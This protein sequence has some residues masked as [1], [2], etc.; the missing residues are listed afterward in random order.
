M[1]ASGAKFGRYEIQSQLGAGG[2]GEVYL[3]HDTEL[4]RFVALKVLP[5]EFCCDAE[6]VSRFKQEA[7]AAS[8]LNHPNIITIYEIGEVEDR[9]FI[10]TEFIDGET[11]RERIEKNDLTTY[12]SVK[13]AEQVAAALS[14]AH[15]S[16]IIHRDIK[17]EN[18]MIRRDRIVKILD[19][20]L[21]KLV[22]QR[23]DALDTEAETRAQVNTKAGMI[24][25]T[26]AYM[27]PEQA[28]GK[29]VDARTDIWSLGVVLYEMLTR[30][31]P[32]AGE[33]ISDSI[34]SILK[35]EHPPLDENTP[36][37][38][39]RIVRKALQKNADERYQTIKDFLIDLKNLK[40][41][42]EFTE[43]L[44]R[45]HRPSYGSK[46]PSVSTARLSEDA[47]IIKNAAAITDNRNA[48][49]TSS[50]E[51]VVS[52]IKQHKSASLVTLVV[53]LSAI[54]ALGVW[55]FASRSANATQIESIAVLP[56]VNET[57]NTDNEYLSDGMTESLISS[58]SQIPKLN[59]KA[60]SSVFRYKGKET[61]LRKIAEELN[62]QAILNGR[63]AQRGH[64][65]T[66]YIELVDT[67]TEKVLWSENYNRQMMNLVTLQNEI[68]RDVS[69]KLRTRLSGA[70]EQRVTK[71]HTVNPE[72]YQLYLKGR[73]HWNKRTPEEHKKA[74]GYFEQ[75]I[76]LDPNYALAYA[77]L[78]DCYAVS[79]SP[80]KG[81][82]REQKLRAAANKALELDP[83]LGEPHAALAKS[84]SRE[85]NWS[86]AESEYRRAIEL[87]PNYASAH[88]WYGE[89]LAA[90]GRHDESIRE[91]KRAQEIDPLS[92]VINSD[93]THIL[94]L[95]RRYDE[96]IAQAQKTLEMDAGWMRARW[97][98]SMA[99]LYQDR[100]EEFFA[101][102]EKSLDFSKRSPEEI[103]DYKQELAA[104]K[105]AYRKSG[106][107]GFWQK[108]LEFEMQ[109]YAKGKGN[110]PFYVAE[111]YANLGDKDKALEWLSK[112]I[113]ER[114]DNLEWIKVHPAFDDLRS[115][116]RFQ[117]LL[118]RINLAP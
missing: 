50:A 16:N 78:A 57:G 32:F 83:G 42:L 7:R 77:G 87:N 11:L 28:R 94:L 25:G 98:I 93:M 13:I 53:L 24:M 107:K 23:K 96:A 38:L 89:F 73:F 47:T 20:G 48:T 112:A 55:F 2:M 66:L 103:A 14:V 17:P 69:H 61:D 116:P 9:I 110:S 54:G 88:Q 35:S 74:I 113:D 1:I 117:N 39:N 104:V 40:R 58:L 75:A 72:A 65:L 95:A 63:V 4:D 19:F 43:E 41:E 84:L 62:V 59:V 44:E 36:A 76:A 108:S 27:S 106:A 81:Q 90:L 109:R 21:A 22:E 71:S 51:Y 82:E 100:Y 114:D 33:T 102:E 91:I 26:V 49:T 105:E 64:D 18:I 97:W 60:R 118:R 45:S 86:G 10:A 37:E 79:S 85:W 70:D 31:Q 111:I 115:D 101:N 3:A 34:A 67:N 15:A 46:A 92:L 29:T 52:E 56:F 6:K 12:E 68:A 5:A 8:A 30:R 80:V 99:Y